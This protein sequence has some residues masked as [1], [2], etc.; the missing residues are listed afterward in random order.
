MVP[1]SDSVGSRLPGEH[2]A[3]G[4][5]IA[6]ARSG[7]AFRA[8]SARIFAFAAFADIAYCRVQG[9]SRLETRRVENARRKAISRLPTTTV[10]DRRCRYS[11]SRRIDAKHCRLR[12]V[13]GRLGKHELAES[14]PEWRG[15]EPLLPPT[16]YR[17]G[18]DCF[19]YLYVDTLIR[20]G[21]TAV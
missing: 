19:I 16:R 2:E 6:I 21:D 18:K 12:K 14:V 7:A 3:P 10:V 13:D 11:R 8:Q 15:E 5:E 20:N 9:D 1:T 17:V 4:G